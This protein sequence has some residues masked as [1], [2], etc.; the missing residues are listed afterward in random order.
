LFEAGSKW[1]RYSVR[2]ESTS[3]NIWAVLYRK[4]EDDGQRRV[5][6]KIEKY[7]D[8]FLTKYIM[9]CH[10]WEAVVEYYERMGTT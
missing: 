3:S 2:K 8:N 9:F 7:K 4:S 5:L 1:E 10:V 6:H